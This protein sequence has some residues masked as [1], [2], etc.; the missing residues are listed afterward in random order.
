MV[1]CLP[2]DFILQKPHRGVSDVELLKDLQSVASSLG[3][4]TVTTEEYNKIGIY[5][6]CT[7]VRRFGSWLR[8]LDAAKL[9]RTRTMMNIPEEELFDNLEALRR[10]FGRQPRY[11]EVRKPLSRYAAE[12]YAHR[13]GSFFKALEAFVSSM[14]GEVVS[15]RNTSGTPN[16][17]SINYRMRFR[18]LQR[19]NF[20]CCA[21]G[22]SPAKDSGVKLHIDH[23][24][25][26]SKGGT[27]DLSNLQTLCEKCNLGKSN[28]L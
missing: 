14:N 24:I 28:V 18:V 16:P 27:C 22:A 10:H 1:D 11:H 15:S 6:S 9:P 7:F 19:D 8:A 4:D 25:P 12:T 3:Q 17:R 2:M 13:F 20:K 5:H 26:V 21:C 23:I